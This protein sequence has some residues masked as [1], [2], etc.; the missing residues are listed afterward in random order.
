MTNASIDA[1]LE[2]IGLVVKDADEIGEVHASVSKMAYDMGGAPF[3]IPDHRQVYAQCGIPYTVAAILINGS[4]L[5]SD[6]VL[7]K[8]E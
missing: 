6:S 3:K 2:L 5:L 4:V 1:V 8:I 7:D